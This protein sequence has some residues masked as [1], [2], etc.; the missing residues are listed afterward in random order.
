M[1]PKCGGKS[2]NGFSPFPLGWFGCAIQQVT[3]KGLP[4]FFFCFNILILIYF[5]KYETI[6][7]FAPTFWTHIISELGDVMLTTPLFALSISGIYPGGNVW[8]NLCIARKSEYNNF[9]KTGEYTS[10]M[11]D[12]KYTNL[13]YDTYRVLYS[14]VY[15][16]H[17]VQIQEL[18]IKIIL[19]T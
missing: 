13:T 2:G 11:W 10:K 15:Q 4:G 7:T 1:P 17:C 5:F 18:N 9:L 3:S 12:D 6:S 14:C 16:P 8:C 19:Y